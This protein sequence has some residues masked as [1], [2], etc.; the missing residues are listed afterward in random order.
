MLFSI[1]KKEFTEIFR[2]K[3]FIVMM[4]V[5]PLVLITTLGLGLKDIMTNNNMF[6]ENDESSKVYYTLDESSQYANGFNEAKKGIEDAINVKFVE[7]SSLSEVEGDVDNYNAYFHVEIADDGFKV[8]S[9]KSGERQKGKIVRNVFESVL[10]Q[11]ASHITIYKENPQAMQNLIKSK[12][13]EYVVKDSDSLEDLSSTQYYTFAE[14]ALI[15]FYISSTVGELVYSERKLNTID[16]VFLSKANEASF[17]L[18]KTI[19]GTIIAFLQ[20]ITVYLYSTYVLDVDWGENVLKFIFIFV[21]FG[22]F[23]SM[24]GAVTGLISKN[25]TTVSGVLNIITIIVC[26][27]GGCYIPLSLI[28]TIPV[29]GDLVILSPIYWINASI[30]SI[31]CGAESNAFMVSIGSSVIGTFVLLI[32][33]VLALRGKG[34]VGNV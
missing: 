5:F 21:C 23:V 2:T 29:I 16:R 7:S 25:D 20:T 13:D 11:Y 4:F 17:L 1:L 33:F 15:I 9:P 3:S 19:V 22:L 26:F 27:L 8:Y 6:S 12:Y 10:N 32:V 31:L 34:G 18:A 28:T 30:G 24:L 14:L